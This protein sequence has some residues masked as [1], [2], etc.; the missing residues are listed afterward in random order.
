LNINM[1]YDDNKLMVRKLS[2]YTIAALVIFIALVIA[3]GLNVFKPKARK[4]KPS[5]AVPFVTTV[6]MSPVTETIHIETYGEIVPAKKIE[7]F[8]QVEG[9]A[10]SVH[11]D[12]VPGGT[13]KKGER[14]LQVDPKD[15]E[16]EIRARKALVS[17]AR[18]A[19]RMEKAQQSIAQKEWEVTG[20]GPS[21]GNQD[22]SLA[23]RE[24]Q[25]ESMLANLDAAES[26]LAAARLAKDR[27]AIT[28]PFNAL[29][30]EKSIDLGHLVNR[31]RPIATLAGTDEF[32]VQVSVPTNRLKWIRFPGPKE[33][34]G[35][36]A[37]IIIDTGNGQRTVRKA[38]VYKLLGELDPKGKMARVLLSL[39]DPLK[40][41]S[42]AD[43]K[44]DIALLGSFV[45][46]SIEA[47]RLDSVYP[48]ARKAMRD[49]NRVWVLSK[50]NTLEIRDVEIVWHRKDDLLI[51]SGLNPGDRLITSRIQS[52]L[53]GMSLMPEGMKNKAAETAGI[54]AAQSR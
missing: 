22:R 25:I 18:L 49:N 9:K 51:S 6:R 13:I 30:L 15:Y 35:S 1:I 42:R 17:E 33:K 44:G 14:I 8:A 29:V 5:P 7:V 2:K 39:P 11:P 26:A 32:W 37:E 48:V 53:P 27:T 38:V 16:L 50:D 3:L 45:K 20:T 28:S 24:P 21:K 36:T 52:P 23:L 40:L 31:Q 34:T 46:V 19:L 10:I 12:L 47:G 41:S 54:P 4:A 43:H